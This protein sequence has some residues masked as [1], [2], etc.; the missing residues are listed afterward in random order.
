MRFD[1]LQIFGNAGIYITGNIQVVVILPGNFAHWNKT[2]IMGIGFDL[3]VESGNDF[4]NIPLTQAILVA[5]FYE[6]PAGINHKNASALISIFL[7][8]DNDTSRNTCAIEQICRQP[9]DSLDKSGP[10]KGLSDFTLGITTEQDTMRQN[11]SSLTCS[12][13]GFQNVHQPCIVA[14][15]L[16]RSLTIAIETAVLF[17]SIRPVLD[18][19]RGIGD[20]IIKAAQNGLIRSILKELG[21]RKC[22]SGYNG[23]RCP[24]VQHRIH[25]CKACRGSVLFLTI[26]GQSNRSLVQGSNQERSRAAGGIINCCLGSGFIGNADYFCQNTRYFRGGIE[27]SLALA[28]FGGKLPHQIF[29]GITN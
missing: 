22:I 25:F 24:V 19:K 12:F 26:A 10:D 2:G 7:V 28:A 15:F 16:G 13:Q 11:D 17:Q 20:N 6:V 8:D 3:L 23:S 5:V 4:I 29:I 21:I 18:R 14:V 9:D 1:T 27:L